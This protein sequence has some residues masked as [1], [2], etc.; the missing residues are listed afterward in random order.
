VP[1]T[2]DTPE[3]YGFRVPVLLPDLRRFR[4]GRQVDDAVRTAA[5]LVTDGCRVAVVPEPGDDVV[6]L[7]TA[8]HDAGLAWAC[9]LD[10]R[11]ADLVEPV[12]ASGV[13]VALCGGDVHPAARVVVR[14]DEPGAEERCRALA[15]R[16]VRLARGRHVLGRPVLGRQGTDLTFVRCLNVLM[17]GAGR[18]GIA[19]TDP[20]LIA[21]AGERAAWNGRTPDTW[22]HVLPYGTLTDERRRLV[23]SGC[24]VR[25][26]VRAG[27]IPS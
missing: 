4:T 8:L 10:L 12:L 13:G 17:A 2:H 25:V 22:E 23:A 27:R 14:A 20:R 1:R 11:D 18:P 9:E 19:G 3:H 24:T 16:P 7:A 6:A 5:E 21:I 26:S 15:D